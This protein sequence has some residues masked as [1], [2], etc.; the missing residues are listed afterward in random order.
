M[1]ICITKIMIFFAFTFSIQITDSSGWNDYTRELDFRFSVTKVN[2]I[3]TVVQSK[4]GSTTLDDFTYLDYVG[5]VVKYFQNSEYTLFQ[6]KYRKTS[7]VSDSFHDKKYLYI[8]ASSK[9]GDISRVLKEARFFDF[10]KLNNLV[11]NWT[12]LSNPNFLLPMIGSLIFVVISI[13]YIFVELWPVR[14]IF[15]ILFSIVIYSIYTFYIIE[16]H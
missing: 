15:L 16:R 8:I 11:V 1:Y 10:V 14:F 5:P 2:S 12:K 6:C 13:P 9:S 3:E 4:N 7:Y